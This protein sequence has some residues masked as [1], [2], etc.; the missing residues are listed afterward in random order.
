MHQICHAAG[1][2]IRRMIP[3]SGLHEPIAYIHS[4]TENPGQERPKHPGNHTVRDF[5]A[6][7]AHRLVRKN[8]VPGQIDCF[9]KQCKMEAHSPKAIFSERC[10]R[11]PTYITFQLA[12][13]GEKAEQ[14]PA[15][16]PDKTKNVRCLERVGLL[17]RICFDTPLE[18]FTSPWP[19]PMAARRV[20]KKSKGSGI[21]VSPTHYRTGNHAGIA[22][23][24]GNQQ[25]T[26]QLQ[27]VE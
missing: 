10:S 20:P 19:Q 2:P 8:P 5:P 4:E 12:G 24:P 15:R 3:K 23:A 22:A 17:S 14:L 27:L 11:F 26:M 9:N 13:P 21:H 16:I 7:N 1:L 25:S 18:V 6:S